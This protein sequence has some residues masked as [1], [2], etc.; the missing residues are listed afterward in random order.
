VDDA[1]I[2]GGPTAHITPPSTALARRKYVPSR[3]VAN[4]QV[5]IIDAP[6]AQEPPPHSPALEDLKDPE[7]PPALDPTRIGLNRPY[8]HRVRYRFAQLTTTASI[9]ATAAAVLVLVLADRR[10]AI[11][12]A[13]AGLATGFLAVFLGMRS[14]MASRIVGYSIAACALGALMTVISVVLPNTLFEE[15]HPDQIPQHTETR[16]SKPT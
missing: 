10:L 9:A 16:P 15:K 2:T 12:I 3:A 14:R 8:R 4:D 7:A 13:A 1:P 5:I 11:G 6:R